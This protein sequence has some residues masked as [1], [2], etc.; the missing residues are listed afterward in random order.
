MENNMLK[1]KTKLLM[2]LICTFLISVSSVYATSDI[3][4]EDII[5]NDEEVYDN[6]E[7]VIES[8]IE[9]ID[10]VI[11]DID[12]DNDFST[13]FDPYESSEFI[14]N[15][16][17]KDI[18]KNDMQM[19]STSSFPSTFT[20]S[21]IAEA[22]IRVRAWIDA[23]GKLPNFVT[24]AGI[25]ITMPEMYYLLTKVVVDKYNTGAIGAPITIK[26]NVKNPSSPSG[27]SVSGSLT[28]AQYS[29]NAQSIVNFIN[30]NN[31][32]PNFV[33]TALG[34]MQYQTSIY[35]YCRILE[36]TYN[37][38]AMPATT[39]ISV[40][41]SHSMNKN[42]PSHTRPTNPGNPGT[43]PI[44]T[45]PSS[46]YNNAYTPGSL[47]LNNF[48]IATKNCQVNDATLKAKALDLIKG[49]TTQVGQATA[50]FNWVRNSIG[51]EYY[52]D[53]RHGA[54]AT[55]NRGAGNCVDQSHLLIALYRGAGFPAR[56]VNG[57]AV[58]STG[59][60]GHTWTQVL[61]GNTWVVG[62]PISSSNALGSIKNWNSP[63]I[64]G[65]YNE[66]NF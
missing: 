6:I 19:M 7:L 43:L 4:V 30:T 41:I 24:I 12:I 47:N 11:E 56:Y 53:T 21:Q 51:Y 16:L 1:I 33:S 34:N 23:N 9:F 36:V 10:D 15:E 58:F 65:Y 22:G 37:T 2:L 61:I 5:Q 49:Q 28:K 52:F 14:K 45:I 54:K 59:R 8:D 39:S 35:M 42:L 44:G 55:F 50:I 29:T 40:A 26:Y 27:V 46:I 66:I 32:A 48:L 25:E 57:N 13:E 17:I 64:L 3:N 62:D 18:A 60:I 38:G 63:N 31:Q 20:M